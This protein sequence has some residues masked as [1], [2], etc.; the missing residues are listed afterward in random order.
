MKSAL[1]PST[2]LAIAFAL[3]ASAPA[4]QAG[5]RSGVNWSIS[6]GA[7]P[8]V[9]YAP[10]P[11]VY[12]YPQPVYVQPQPVYVE[13]PPVIVYGAPGYVTYSQPYYVERPRHRHHHHDRGHNDGNARQGAWGY[14]DRD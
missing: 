1:F 12:S 9:V 3:L 2:L 6:V 4:A 5:D 8:A 14:R 13:Q 7:G 11:V 10:P